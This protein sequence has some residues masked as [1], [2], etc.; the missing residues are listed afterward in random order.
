MSSNR[1]ALKA[2]K[3]SPTL[4]RENSQSASFDLL[5]LNHHPEPPNPPKE[6]KR[7]KG[8]EGTANHSSDTITPAGAA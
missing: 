7:G 8:G 2:L 4:T 6:K 3:A 1:V 5:R